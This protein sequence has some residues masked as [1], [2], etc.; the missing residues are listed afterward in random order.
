[1]VQNY[2][3]EG[4]YLLPYALFSYGFTLRWL[5]DFELQMTGYAGLQHV[6]VL[7][8][9]LL[10]V[11]RGDDARQFFRRRMMRHGK[12]VIRGWEILRLLIRHGLPVHKE[13][14]MRFGQAFCQ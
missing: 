6:V 11:F 1:M 7:R 5:S 4:P 3:R 9:D 12:V 13:A 10:Q 14:Q 8:Q 2:K